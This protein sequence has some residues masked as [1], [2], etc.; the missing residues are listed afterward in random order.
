MAICIK[1]RK[2]YHNH[3]A[4]LYL[5]KFGSKFQKLQVKLL[6]LQK[7]D[8][9]KVV[10]FLQKASFFCSSKSFLIFGDPTMKFL[11]FWFLL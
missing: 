3:E 6:K 9:K 5:Y 4:N 2:N 10:S 7:K 1:T 8:R 11:I